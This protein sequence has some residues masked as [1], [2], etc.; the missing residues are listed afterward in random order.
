MVSSDSQRISSRQCSCEL[1]IPIGWYEFPLEFRPAP[2]FYH[3]VGKAW[4]YEPTPPEPHARVLFTPANC[5]SIEY[6]GFHHTEGGKGLTCI[7]RYVRL[8]RKL[9][10]NKV[11]LRTISGWRDEAAG[12]VKQAFNVF[13]SIL[14]RQNDGAIDMRTLAAK[15][16]SL[17][18]VKPDQRVLKDNSGWIFMGLAATIHSI[19]QEPGGLDY[20]A[21]LYEDYNRLGGLDDRQAFQVTMGLL[22]HIYKPTVSKS[23]LSRPDGNN[24]K[25]ER[26]IINTWEGMAQ[27]R[28]DASRYLEVMK[29]RCDFTRPEMVPRRY[30][31]AVV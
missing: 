3:L 17:L 15:V 16:N 23:N 27:T 5:F 31:S 22:Y 12:I 26:E 8:T 2:I 30:Q 1:D 20:C 14:P 10:L 4:G 9:S 18:D 25:T 24:W 21:M 6:R 28:L 19:Y 13:D 11:H 7:N 29:D